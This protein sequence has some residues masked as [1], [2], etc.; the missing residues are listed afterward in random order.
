MLFLSNRRVSED[1]SISATL[2]DKEECIVMARCNVGCSEEKHDHKLGVDTELGLEEY[3]KTVHCSRGCDELSLCS[4]STSTVQYPGVGQ[5]EVPCSTNTVQCPG[6]GQ[7][8]VPCS[9]NTLTFSPT[10]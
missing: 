8:E 3:I 9:T 2:D 10:N 7:K 5:R 1:I 4:T 6:F